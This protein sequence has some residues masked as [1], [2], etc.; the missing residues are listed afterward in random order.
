MRKILLF[1]FIAGCTVCSATAQ[2]PL[3]ERQKRTQAAKA[4][5]GEQLEKYKT[6]LL[7]ELQ[8]K[9]EQVYQEVAQAFY[10]LG[11]E[12][13]TDSIFT[14]IRKKFPRG[15]YV[16]NTSMSTIYDEKDPVKKEKLYLAWLKRFPAEKLG[17]DIV[18]D[19]ARYDVGAAF[20]QAGRADKAMSYAKAMTTKTWRGEGYSG[21]ARALVQG[22]HLD[23][24]AELYKMAIENAE[25][26]RNENDP[27]ARFALIGY[28]AY[29]S[30]YA[31]VC[32]RLGRKA[33]ALE[34]WEKLPADRRTPV[35]AEALAEAGRPMEAFLCLLDMV[36]GGNFDAGI[37]EKLQKLYVTMNGSDQGFDSYIEGL[38][39]ARAE[40]KRRE[41]AESMLSEPAPD[42]T[43]TDTY[44]KT[45]RLSDLRGKVVVLDFWAT[46][47]GPC[48][49]S[50][51][52]MQKAVDKYKNDPGVVFLFIHTW[53]RNENATESA[54]EYLKENNYSFR[55]LMDLKDP[56]TKAN[57]V[58]KS[59]G[60]TGIPAKFVIDPQGNIR[61]KVTGAAGSDEEIVAELSQMIE[62]ARQASR[63]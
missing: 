59:Y 2:R 5:G 23:Q 9:D 49:R 44:G 4:A 3:D 31:D 61:F 42:F 52:A 21:I 34:A 17:E 56:A 15:E 24:A 60:V 7:A 47:C 14:V 48:K 55:L 40:Q 63:Q 28:P 19:Y 62:M 45:V 36:R 54:V 41:V 16:R 11:M 58:V 13:T 27:G 33:E 50:F 38:R 12:K 39:K 10:D 30:A 26:L 8:G 29:L 35:Y 1:V 57:T 51:P 20:A 53:E 37:V 43:L 6:E 22:E 32:Y 46:W 18:Y 25:T